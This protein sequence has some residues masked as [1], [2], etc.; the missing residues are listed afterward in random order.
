MF[1]RRSCFYCIGLFILAFGVSLTIISQ[2]GA[3]AWDALSVGLSNRYGGTVG[4]WIIVIGIVLFF[5]NSLL[6]R[7]M[8]EWLSLITIL[9]LGYFIDFW[10]LIIWKDIIIHSFIIQLLI[11]LLGALH[12]GL[13][14]SVYLQANFALIPIDR[15]ML[16]LQEIFR[17]PLMVA[18]T[19]TELVALTGAW[20]IGGP[21]GVGTFIVTVCVGPIIQFFFPKAEWLMLRVRKEKHTI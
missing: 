17:F 6:Q 12:V 14:I 2:L 9:L 15:F 19:C 16:N 7:K 13:G 18:K 20:L 8:P 10:L 5:V 4:S 1:W 11:L 3:G 21:I